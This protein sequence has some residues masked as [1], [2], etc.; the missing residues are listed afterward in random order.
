MLGDAPQP[1]AFLR[2]R[3]DAGGQ[4]RDGAKYFEGA[5]E[6]IVE[7]SVTSTE[8]DFGPKRKLYQRAGVREYITVETL[9]K[10]LIWRALEGP[11]YVPIEALEDGIV[12]SRVFPGLWLDVA[13]FWN[14]DESRMLAALS[15][16]LA[17]REHR[18]FIESLAKH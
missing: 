1:G 8:V 7:V 16:G 9:R 2:I 18:R 12:R 15:Q 3:P 5:P 11:E 17:T 6:L 4:S 13:A 10:R 14:G